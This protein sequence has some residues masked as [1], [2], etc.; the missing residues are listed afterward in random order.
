VWTYLVILKSQCVCGNVEV[1]VCVVV[2]GHI[3][4]RVGSRSLAVVAF[5]AGGGRLQ[6]GERGGG[7]ATA[8]L[9]GW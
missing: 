2:P 8:E 6:R 7:R 3:E 9:G 5:P 4:V 1:K